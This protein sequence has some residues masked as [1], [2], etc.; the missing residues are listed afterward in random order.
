MLQKQYTALERGVYTATARQFYTGN[1]SVRREHVLEAGGF[2][3]SL[4]RAEDVE[5]AFRLQ[6]HGLAFAY[7]PRAVG[8]HYAERSFTAW[9]DIASAY[10]RNDVVF[11]RDRGHAEVYDWIASNYRARHSLVRA[12]TR[13]CVGHARATDVMSHALRGAAAAGRAA[14]LEAV[15]RTALSGIY[16]VA[17][18]RGVAAELGGARQ[19]WQ[20][21]GRYRA[22]SSA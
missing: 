11:A 8:L 16:N 17:Y 10:G 3:T 18:Y 13:A 6:D 5:L 22:D 4:R 2:D 12:M 1:A 15:S 14:R 21:L 19:L 9:L 7:E 20:V